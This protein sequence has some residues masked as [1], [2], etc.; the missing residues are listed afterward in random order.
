MLTAKAMMS[1]MEIIISGWKSGFSHA[2]QSCYHSCTLGL[3]SPERTKSIV[4]YIVLLYLL[5]CCNSESVD[6]ISENKMAT[7]QIERFQTEWQA[8]NNHGGTW[9]QDEKTKNCI[10]YQ[11]FI[12]WKKWFPLVTYNAWELFNMPLWKSSLQDWCLHL[13]KNAFQALLFGFLELFYASTS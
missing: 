5:N 4:N 1:N 8:E 3:V 7:F 12:S 2:S 10:G 13:R 9:L 6:E 11:I